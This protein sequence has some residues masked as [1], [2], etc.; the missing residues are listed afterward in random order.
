LC[1]NYADAGGKVF[2]FFLCFCRVHPFCQFF[3]GTLLFGNAKGL[4]T[5]LFL[6][7]LYRS[8]SSRLGT[9]VFVLKL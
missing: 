4:G 6:L 8:G 2:F 7:L 1:C 5:K 3:F 9:V